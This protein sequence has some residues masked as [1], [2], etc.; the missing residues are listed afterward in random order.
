MLGNKLGDGAFA[1]V[2]EAIDETTLRIVAVKAIDT[3]RIRKLRGGLDAVQREIAV[4]KRLRHDNVIELIDVVRVPN[5][6]RLYIVLE[7]ANGCSVEE[8][9]A[10]GDG[11]L[12][13]HQVANIVAQTLAALHYM[14]GRGVVHRDV[15]PSNLMLSASGVVKISDFGVA[16]FL[17]EYKD[18]D[19]VSRT[20][21]SPAFQAPEIA[22][23]EIKYSGMKVDVWA[24]GVTTY[25]LL[26]GKVPFF[27][28]SLVGLFDV[29]G[30][31]VYETP[32]NVSEGARD[33]IRRMLTV[34]WRQR[35]GVDE[36]L[37]HSWITKAGIEKSESSGW[38]ST[39]VDIPKRDSSVMPI[40][41]RM[42]NDEKDERF[43]TQTTE[44][45]EEN[46]VGP[47]C[48]IV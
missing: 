15:K 24:L 13:E 14:H 32:E 46:S 37:K 12:P 22:T 10:L 45:Q 44:A 27:S 48:C 21:G 29:I 40:L 41:K 33:V 34:D 6:S 2:K 31:G 18:D 17:D 39:W 23:G 1:T 7:L 20:S 25:L 47:S 19:N 11:K 30:K 42:Y 4:Q 35:A 16:E 43:K 3:R 26:T 5:K 9:A 8:L 28:E 38:R 36:L